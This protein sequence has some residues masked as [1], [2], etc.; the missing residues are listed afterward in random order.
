M[1]LLLIDSIFNDGI[2]DIIL[3]STYV[4]PEKSPIFSPEKDIYMQLYFLQ[5]ILKQEQNI[6]GIYTK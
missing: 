2:H 6:F 5:E 1:C 4:A 3:I